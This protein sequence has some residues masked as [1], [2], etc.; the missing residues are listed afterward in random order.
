M[1]TLVI[2]TGSSSIKYQ[3]LDMPDGRIL[4]SGLL[5]RI[6]EAKGRI[7]HKTGEE[8]NEKK[9]T[10][11]E[12]I[13]DH[14]T[15]MNRLAKLISDPEI[16]VL[17]NV[18]EVKLVG[19]RIVH[20]GD[21]FHSITRIDDKVKDAIVEL[22]NLAPLHN[23][24][25]LIGINTAE[26]V[27]PDA[28]QVGV[29]DTA[30]H[31]SI[32]ETAFR[33]ALPERFYKVNGIRAYGF[34]G[35]SHRYVSRIAA[36]FLNKKPE[37]TSLI[38]LHLG[39]GA[40]VCAVKNG[41]SID[42][43]LGMSTITGLIMGTRV[44]DIDPGVI[45]YMQEMLGLGYKEVKKILTSE[46][47]LLG[48]SGDNDLRSLSKR[49]EE[50]D[51]QAILALS[52]YS[53][54]IKKYIGAYLAAIGKI[55]ALVFTAG[56]GENSALI[57]ALSTQDLEHIGIA[58]DPSKNEEKSSVQRDISSKGA[59]IKTLVIPTNEEYEI[60]RQAYALVNEAI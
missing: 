33:Y 54:R 27:F 9:Y 31:Q 14:Q 29:F 4:C 53:Y 58:L 24:A 19:H 21:R 8:K 42:T 35:T 16:G 6:G 12:I 10:F 56:V 44:G 25:N 2:N 49:Y 50:G 3:L 32:P 59:S 41:K 28:E 55:D 43:S 48:L 60:A 5:E 13:P 51:P 30:F 18:N 34:H 36:Q 46:S 7:I 37:E 47:G 20:G 45:I 11:D 38:T 23:P 40:S 26:H 57:R 17:S 52:I 22:S 1:K 39:N 15:G